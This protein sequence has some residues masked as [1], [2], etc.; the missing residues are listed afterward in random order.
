MFCFKIRFRYVAAGLVIFLVACQIF[1]YHLKCA[2]NFC[3]F[4]D[5]LDALENCD[6]EP[7]PLTNW[8]GRIAN[9]K[10]HSFLFL[11]SDC[12]SL[13]PVDQVERF[14]GIAASRGSNVEKVRFVGSE[15]VMHF[16]R[17]PKVRYNICIALIDDR[18]KNTPREWAKK[19]RKS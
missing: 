3:L 19:Y 14:A 4:G 11:Y 10:N 9:M 2:W 7:A 13:I 1:W 6:N 15:H 16:R 17:Y 12:D 5:S 18:I 8:L